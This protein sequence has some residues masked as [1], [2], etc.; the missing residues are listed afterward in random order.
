MNTVVDDSTLAFFQQDESLVWSLEAFR[1]YERAVA[2]A[3]HLSRRLCVYSGKVHQLYASYDILVPPDN[4]AELVIAPHLDNFLDMWFNI[5]EKA[6]QPTG[7]TIVPGRI[8]QKEGLALHTSD[9]HSG[10]GRVMPL[11]AGLRELRQQYDSAGDV[12]LPVITKGDL[13]AFRK[14]EPVMHLHR[15]DM[16]ALGDKSAFERRDI[17]QG[18]LKLLRG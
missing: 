10:K 11:E 2:F 17:R 13:R 5:P 15:L 18:I 6:V 3:T 7:Q 16:N 9:S 1:R 4:T 14:E 12:F 8:V